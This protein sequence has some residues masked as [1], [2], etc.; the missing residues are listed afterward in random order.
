MELD[1]NNKKKSYGEIN[2]LNLKLV[3]AL[4]R[5]LLPEEK[6]LTALLSD[7]GLTI[8]QFGVLESLYH[9][10]PM[11]IKEIIKKSLS[12]SGNMTVVIRNLLK[13]NYI[14]KEKDP[15]DGRAFIIKITTKGHNLIEEIF[16]EHLVKLERVFSSLE[17][18]E[19]E[20]LL[21]LLKKL[22][23]YNPE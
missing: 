5:S 4:R 14:T 8:S 20:K 18:D 7:N 17:N 12:S 21:E 13:N 19:K 23:S 1:R 22:N 9:I 3:I 6:Y 15:E 2:D 16:P 11:N 10:G